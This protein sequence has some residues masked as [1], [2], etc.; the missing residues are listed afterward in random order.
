MTLTPGILL[1]AVGAV[2]AFAVKA[3]VSGLD[4]HVVGWILMATGV[5]ATLLELA[6]FAPRRRRVVSSTYAAAPLGRT[7]VRDET[8]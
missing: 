7:V 5:T 2:L 3:T 6:V 8:W 4:V 1:T